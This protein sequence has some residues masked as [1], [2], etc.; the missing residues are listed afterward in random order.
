ME[1]KHCFLHLFGDFV[2]WFFFLFLK[3]LTVRKET[4]WSFSCGSLRA[5]NKELS[6]FP[7]L[8]ELANIYGVVKLFVLCH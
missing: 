2:C 5:V 7:V 8:I 1:G 3:S 6:A 4:F